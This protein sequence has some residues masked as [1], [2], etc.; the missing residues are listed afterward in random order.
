MGAYPHVA[1]RYVLLPHGASMG[2]GYGPIVVA[3]A[4]R[5]VSTSCAGSRS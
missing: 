4:S 5:S 3:R 2:L 1:D